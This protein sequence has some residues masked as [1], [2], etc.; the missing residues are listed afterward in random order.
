MQV[1]KK[2]VSLKHFKREKGQKWQMLQKTW[3]K[4]SLRHPL[5]KPGPLYSSHWFWWLLGAAPPITSETLS[6]HSPSTR[7]RHT[8][9]C[10]SPA[11]YGPRPS[12]LFPQSHTG[13]NM[14]CEHR[15]K[16]IFQ[17]YHLLSMSCHC[18]DY[19]PPSPVTKLTEVQTTLLQGTKNAHSAADVSKPCTNS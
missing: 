10:K 18:P 8:V 15:K 11:G 16:N 13:D 14:I 12:S 7:S 1:E 6:G 9:S 19:F 2:V 4:D 17:T 5:N 3:I